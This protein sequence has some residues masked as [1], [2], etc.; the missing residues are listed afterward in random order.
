MKNATTSPINF[1][2]AVR[3]GMNANMIV[4]C[5]DKGMVIVAPKA[6]ITTKPDGTST[7]NLVTDKLGKEYKS[8]A[9]TTGFAGDGDLIE[10]TSGLKEGDTIGIVQN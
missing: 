1:K 10:I 9:V 6:A 4:T 5:A 7:V 3:P 8:V 2:D